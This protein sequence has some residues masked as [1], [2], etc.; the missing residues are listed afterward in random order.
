MLFSIFYVLD[1]N[2]MLYHADLELQVQYMIDSRIGEI[3]EWFVG[4]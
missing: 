1:V 2:G 4:V 3:L